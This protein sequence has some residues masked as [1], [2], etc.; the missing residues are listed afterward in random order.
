VRLFTVSF[1]LISVAILA[2]PAHANTVYVTQSDALTAVVDRTSDFPIGGEI[3]SADAVSQPDLFAAAGAGNAA[4]PSCTEKTGMNPL[5]GS[6]AC[7]VSSGEPL[8]PVGVSAFSQTGSPSAAAAIPEAS[9]LVLLG[10]GL[11]VLWG[12]SRY[13]I[14]PQSSSAN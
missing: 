7:L 5:Y 14:R 12:V 3:L 13:R 6:F 8:T 1:V 9:T 4:A 2:V 10:S 11:L